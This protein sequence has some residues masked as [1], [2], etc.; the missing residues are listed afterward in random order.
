MAL[1]MNPEEVSKPLVQKLH[2]EWYNVLFIVGGIVFQMVD[3]YGFDLYNLVKFH[4]TGHMWYFCWT[5]ALVLLPGISMSLVSCLWYC[6]S[7]DNTSRRAKIVRVLCHI[8]LLS[9]VTRYNYIILY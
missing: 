4:S 7:T 1:L 5:L 9:P 3:M 8:L 6:R 2:F